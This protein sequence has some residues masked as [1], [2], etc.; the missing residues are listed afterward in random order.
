[1]N[2]IYIVLKN[3]DFTEGRGPMVFHNA[4][5]TPA[6]ACDYVR[7]QEGIYGSKQEVEVVREKDVYARGNGYD[8]LESPL[9]SSLDQVLTFEKEI[10]KAQALAKLSAAER[11]ALGL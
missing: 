10:L 4:F 5:T 2:R 7:V 11:K 3:A 8:I 9:Y 1:M 6:L